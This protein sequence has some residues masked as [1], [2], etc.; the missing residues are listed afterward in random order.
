MA[1]LMRK[2]MSFKMIRFNKSIKR[3]TTLSS[4]PKLKTLLMLRAVT[5][6]LRIKVFLIFYLIIMTIVLSQPPSRW[7]REEP[8]N[9]GR[10]RR[11][12]H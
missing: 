11:R 6:K 3:V 1:T 2:K 9:L 12:E 7:R 5:S 8:S 10:V 4:S